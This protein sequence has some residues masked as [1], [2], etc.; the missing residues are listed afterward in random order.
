MSLGLTVQ[1][2]SN[3][4]LV[5]E[6]VQ[7]QIALLNGGPDGP[8]YSSVAF[9]DGFR[10]GAVQVEHGKEGTASTRHLSA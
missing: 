4:K 6:T 1:L 2:I 5:S 9:D 8:D 10:V 7:V 3:F